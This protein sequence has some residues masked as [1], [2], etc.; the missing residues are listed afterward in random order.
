MKHYTL[1]LLVALAFV[2]GGCGNGDDGNNGSGN[3]GETDAG[4]VDAGDVGDMDDTGSADTGPDDTGTTDT[5]DDTGMDAGSDAEQPQPCAADERVEAGECEACAPGTTNEAGDDPTG[6]DTDCDAILCAENERVQD[7]TC[8]ACPA[9]E[10]SDAG[11]D[12]SGDGTQCVAPDAC[13]DVLGL[14]CDTYREAYIK[15]DVQDVVAK[16]GSAVA[17]SDDGQTLF[18]GAPNFNPGIEPGGAVFVFG[19]SGATW[20]QLARLRPSEGNNFGTGLDIDGNTLAVAANGSGRVHLYTGSSGTWTEDDVVSASNY[21]SGDRFGLS[22]ALDARG[23]LLAVAAINEDGGGL[24]FEADPDATPAIEDS[25]AVYLYERDALGDWSP[26]AYIK[27]PNAGEAH[28]F[29]HAVA[30]SRSGAHLAIGANEEDGGAIGINGDMSNQSADRSGA[31]YVNR[32][33]P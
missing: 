3:N 28:R 2:L 25:G 20:T 6:A 30:L 14:D 23:E 31:V 9:G 21:E 8:V 19:R 7:N 18:V 5:G 32:L 13:F 11:A 10:V 24:G 1:V 17:M 29:G 4:M 27:A 26:V 22:L 12:A 16:F 15:T 33:A